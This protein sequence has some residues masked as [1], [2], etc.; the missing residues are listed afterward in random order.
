MKTFL[1]AQGRAAAQ[2]PSVSTHSR[3][4][5][6]G[7]CSEGGIDFERETETSFSFFRPLANPGWICS[8]VPL[9]S[10]LRRTTRW[11][12]MFI[13]FCDRAHGAFPLVCGLALHRLARAPCFAVHFVHAFSACRSDCRVRRGVILST[14]QRFDFSLMHGLLPTSPE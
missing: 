10:F 5:T 7:H 4:L 6:E 12:H 11:Q 9:S 8:E 3:V 1:A 14:F 2:C 13:L